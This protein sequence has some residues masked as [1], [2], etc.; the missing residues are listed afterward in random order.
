MIYPQK[1]ANSQ[2]AGGPT[3]GEDTKTNP[4]APD[5][6]NAANLED[7]PKETLVNGDIFAG[8]GFGG[9]AGGGVDEPDLSIGSL[10]IGGGT[11]GDTTEIGAFAAPTFRFTCI[12]N[13]P[14]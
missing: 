8:E 1:W 11:K 9:A 12:S 6:S 4:L 10:G 3:V 7:F 5:A 14:T 2:Y 13:C